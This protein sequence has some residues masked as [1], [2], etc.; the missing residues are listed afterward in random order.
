M[1]LAVTM[2]FRHLSSL[3]A[4]FLHDFREKGASQ[5][6]QED[7]ALLTGVEGNGSIHK[8][9]MD[10]AEGLSTC[11]RTCYACIA[12]LDKKASEQEG[13]GKTSIIDRCW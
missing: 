13:E 6:K 10:I 9:T 1:A 11:E 5:V 2:D 3:L 8:L 7:I 4:T 12:H